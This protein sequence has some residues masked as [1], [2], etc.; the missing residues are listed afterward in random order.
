MCQNGFKR[1]RANP[2]TIY[3]KKFQERLNKEDYRYEITAFTDLIMLLVDT[4]AEANVEL[5]GN[6]ERITKVV[7]EMFRK[8]VCK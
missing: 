2:P 4:M 5:F 7:Q 3:G 8:Y 1:D 6:I